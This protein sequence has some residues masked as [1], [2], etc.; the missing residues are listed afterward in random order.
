MNLY[1]IRH[2]ESMA[3]IEHRILRDIADPH[4]ELS[5]IGLRQAAYTGQALQHLLKHIDPDVESLRLWS[6]PFARTVSTATLVKLFSPEL[7]WEAN[8]REHGLF[9]EPNLSEINFG[10]VDWMNEDDMK[11]I[12]GYWDYRKRYREQD[13]T[14]F[15]RPPHGESR[16]DVYQRVKLFVDTLYRDA[17]QGTTNHVIVTHGRII[18]IF[19]MAM[20]HY[21]FQHMDSEGSPG[22][23]MDVSNASI[24]VIKSDES[25]KHRDYGIVYPGRAS[26]D[27]PD[28]LPEPLPLPKG[29]EYENLIRNIHERIKGLN[30]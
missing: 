11:K 16:S 24:R 28:K 23:T 26:K 4:I 19:A 18:P 1:L 30:L 13:A 21:S 12:E 14:F 3:N 5:D 10:L 17:N 25:G 27:F 22:K 2:A 8:E 15:E 9:I 6:S 7:P 20:M 29:N